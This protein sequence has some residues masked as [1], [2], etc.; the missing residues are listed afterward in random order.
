MAEYRNQ[1]NRERR[2]EL[3]RLRK[4]N[5]ELRAQLAALK[6]KQTG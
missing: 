4:E 1:K 3:E 2:E 6:D 5:A